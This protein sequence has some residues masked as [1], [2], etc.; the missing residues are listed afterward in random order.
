MGLKNKINIKIGEMRK[1]K[2]NLIT[3]VSGVKVGHFT[4]NNGDI[5]TGVTSI[6]PHSKN[7]FKNK[8]V[9]SSYVI[10]GFGKTA[11]L[12][13]I[14]ELN[15]LETPIILTNTLSVGVAFNALVK[16]SL[17]NNK[18]IGVNTGTVNPIVCEC[19]DGYLND[20][21]KLSIKEEHIFEAI[22]NTSVK[23]EEGSIGAGR[24]MSCYGLKGGI[25]SS[26]R[27]VQLDNKD[28]T[29]G[30][31]VLTN[32]GRM[33]DFIINGQYIGKEIEELLKKEE[34]NKKRKNKAAIMEE[35]DK[36]SI[37][38]IIATDIP[39][40]SNSLKRV[41]KRASV[42]IARGGSHIGNGSG[43]IVIAFST[44]CKIPHYKK[45]DIIKTETIHSEKIDTIFR[46]V[47]EAEE[48]AI[49]SSMINATEVT[50]FLA[51][52]RK[53]LKDYIKKL[54]LKN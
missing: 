24:G 15:T 36:G 9:T 3:D 23:F 11:G 52:K 46:A 47:I 6:I 2:R 45:N 16:Y 7:I 17:K 32:H 8:L 42:G 39:L 28:Y 44:A 49:L 50:G 54:D 26:S 33:K 51:H 21:R 13:Q 18:D 40:D 10:N 34:L 20:I 37:I 25:G 19:N 5:Q 22:K 4:I 14:E 31:L 43:E 38:S 27:I 30:V 53:S 48:E 35:K 41:C 1:G 12:I 29:V